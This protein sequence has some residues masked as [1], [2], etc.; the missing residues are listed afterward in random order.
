MSDFDHILNWKLLRGSH[1]FPGP[2]GGTCIN[3]AAI[4]A[5]GFGYRP[6]RSVNAMP[7]CFSRPICELAMQLNDNA[8]N[9]QR[10]RLMPFVTRLACA[11]TPEVE[12][13]RA[14]YIDAH[15]GPRLFPDFFSFD[16]GL[17]ALEGALAIGRQA[18]PLG[19]DEAARRLDAVR[20][21]AEPVKKRSGSL[22]AKV[23][24][25]LGLP[26]AIENVE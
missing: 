21:P 11:D 13:R 16:L 19:L 5:C 2:D 20:G 10:Q 12:Q 17:E 9:A 15:I 26:Q 3:E 23:K 22:P 24:L 14:R 6:V 1:P 18:D 4:V 8:T 7:A 25:W